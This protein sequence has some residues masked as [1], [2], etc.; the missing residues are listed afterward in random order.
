[1]TP[2]ELMLRGEPPI[3]KRRKEFTRVRAIRLWIKKRQKAWQTCPPQWPPQKR[4][5]DPD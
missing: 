3:L 5:H 4:S 2:G 1:V